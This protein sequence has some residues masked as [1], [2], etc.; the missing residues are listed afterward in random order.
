M[1]DKK[2][3]SLKI[4]TATNSRAGGSG[5]SM[6]PDGFL[7]AFLGEQ[8]AAKRKARKRRAGRKGSAM[9]TKGEGTADQTTVVEKPVAVDA[10]AEQQEED[11]DKLYEKAKAEYA[12]LFEKV[13]AHD[14]PIVKWVKY[15]SYMSYPGMEFDM[16]ADGL[17]FDEEGKR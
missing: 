5:V 10:P 12:K 9:K 6:A 14:P 17:Q 3:F 2:Q 8:T 11:L 7:E 13:S 15:P 16:K 4:C 1:A